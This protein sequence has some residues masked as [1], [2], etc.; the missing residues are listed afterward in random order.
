MK[1]INFKF[2]LLFFLFGLISIYFSCSQ[3]DTEDK[4]KVN[5]I[6]ILTSKKKLQVSDFKSSMIGSWEIECKGSCE[7]TLDFYLTT[8]IYNCSCSPCAMDIRFIN[9]KKQSIT[10][11]EDEKKI[12]LN[13]FLNDYDFIKEFKNYLKKNSSSEIINIKSIS[14]IINKNYRFTLIKFIN[15]K[16]FDDSISFY[17][18]LGSEKGYTVDCTGSC[19]CLEQFNPANGTVS[20]S[21]SPCS[22]KVTEIP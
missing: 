22:M 4:K 12:Y 14:N 9:D 10:F 19:N 6:E 13:Y 3:N 15:S 20:C 11:S 18:K 5:E 7:C 1:K 21:C 17:Q 8:G 2:I 16:G